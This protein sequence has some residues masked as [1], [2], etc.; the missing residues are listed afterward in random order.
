MNRSALVLSCV[1]SSLLLCSTTALGQGRFANFETPQTHPVD[2][3][4]VNGADYVLVCNTPD[5]S[6]DIYAAAPPHAFVERV[7]VGMGP[8]TV[9]W[10]P[11]LQK[12]YTCNF[13]GDSVSVVALAPSGA[14]VHGVLERTS[15]LLIGDEPADIAFDPR[16]TVAAVSLSSRSSVTLVN[17]PDLSFAGGEVLLS[18]IDPLTSL[19][20]AVKMPRSIAWLPDG[21]FFAANLRAGAPNPAAAL[22]YDL[23]LYRFDPLLPAPDF[24]GG[25]GSTNHAFAI[26]SAGTLLFMVGTKAQNHAA[27]GVQAVG[28]LKTGFVQSWLMVLDIPSGLAMS[29]HAEAPGGAPPPAALPSINLNRDYSVAALTE[30][31]SSDALVQPSGVLL[32]ESGGSV[33]QIV[34]S[35]YHSDRVAI[36]TPRNNVPGGYVIQRVAIPVLTPASLYS[37]SGPRGLAYSAANNRVFVADRLD[38][39]LAVIDPSSATLT[40]QIQLPNDPTPAE[41]RE[42]RQFLYSNRFS[43]DNSV[44]PATGGFVSCAMCHVDGRT[45]ALP[46]DL[47]DLNLGPAIPAWFHDQN[48][49]D[50]SSMPFFPP[51]KGPLVTQ[52]LQ[53]LVNYLVDDPFQFAATN[54]PYH[55]RGDKADFTNFNE[56]FVN[57]QRMANINTPADPKGVSDGDMIKYRRFVNTI[58]YPPNPEQ[59]LARVT[60]GVLGVNPND[61]LQA[62]GA[63][64]GAMLFHDFPMVFPRGCVDC[65]TLPDGSSNTSTLTFQVPKTLGGGGLV[66]HPFESAAIRGIAQREMIL[67]T[68]YLSTVASQFTANSG[69]LHPGDPFFLNSFSI[70]T[71]VQLNFGMPGPSLADKTTQREALTQFVRQ[72]DTGTAPLAGFAYSV[73]PAANPLDSGLNKTAF[74]LGEAQV[75]EANIGLGVYTRQNGVVRGYW[76]DTTLTPPAYREEGT[77]NTLTRQALLAL[78]VGAGNVVI[79]QGT[80]LGTERRWSNPNGI[81]T[82]ISNPSSVPANL[83][84]ENMAPNTAYVDIPKFNLNLNVGS[85]PDSSIWSLRTLQQ[86]I[87]TAGGMGV[88]AVRH[89]PPRRFRVTGDNIRPG[90]KLLLGLA[91]GTTAASFPVQVMTLE[92][93]PTTHTSNNR[94][95]WE[96]NAELD[97]MHTFALLNGGY[98][99]PDVANVMLRTNGSPSLK[100]VLWNQ[101]LVAVLNEDGALGFNL[102]N[103]QVLRIQDNR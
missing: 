62:S 67:H 34:L 87:V 61:P 50:T 65:H 71:F 101:Y 37:A 102:S 70:N 36:L 72:F 91:S 45:D 4:N 25:L 68:S 32:I 26:N 75:S 47:G 60:P 95:I 12:F 28:A 79:A 92:L 11:A 88:P 81:A 8:G 54:A 21:R 41:I 55:W 52:T 74:D 44:T 73:D 51:Q 40:A 19:P 46:W 22:Q 20:F 33:S 5:N 48:G 94:Q 93:Y 30:V 35:A 84:L 97:A 56:A 24:K 29:V 99:A 39:T 76:F 57:L 77:N 100:P 53:G 38:N 49:K 14:S 96:T 9:R 90:A 59:D 58:L 31:A 15:T 86:S 2:I 82:L 10:N 3:A 16:G 85:P 63:K 7:P 64:L 89:E 1:A 23:G 6:V 18:V 80:P 66:D 42:G 17:A 43:I 27:V 98:W 83:V 103:W 78:S 69:L 13:D